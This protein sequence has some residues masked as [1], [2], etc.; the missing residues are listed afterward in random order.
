METPK[1][2]DGGAERQR[3]AVGEEEA[4]EEE[5]AAGQSTGSQRARRKVPPPT[6]RRFRPTAAPQSAR[7][8]ANRCGGATKRTGLRGEYLPAFAA[9]R[10]GHHGSALRAA[11]GTPPAPLLFPSAL[12]LFPS[13]LIT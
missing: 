7:L 3:A 6:R 9:R 12:V 10:E 13:C 2:Q 8:G 1:Y 4:E 5:A 11:G